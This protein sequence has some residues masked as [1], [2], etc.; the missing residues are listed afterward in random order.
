MPELRRVASVTSIAIAWVAL[1]ACD[2]VV[3]GIQNADKLGGR[4]TD[5]WTR[6]FPLDAAGV[7]QVT[8]TNGKVT[9]EAYDGDTVEVK[10]EKLA[11]AFTDEAAKALLGQITVIQSASPKLVK[12]E[13]KQPRHFG[14]GHA[15]V[16]YTLR[17]PRKA[18]V[19]LDT[20]NGGIEVAGTFAGIEADTVNGGVVAKDLS[21]PLKASAVNGGLTIAL[22]SVSA[23]VHLETTNGGI[24]LTLPGNA[25]ANISARVSNGGISVS[26]IDLDDISERSRRKLDARMNGGGPKIDLETTNG[27]IR[28]G[29]K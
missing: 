6:I 15:E 11:R 4:A 8:N 9:V 26:N 3:G 24:R 28:I 23:D 19:D 10:V 7:V 14:V 21:G 22:A 18:K 5:T 25:K 29:A 16:K 20:T 17:V 1:T 13:T 27:G 2:V 12:F